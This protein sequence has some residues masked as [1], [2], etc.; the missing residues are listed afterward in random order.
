M[1]TDASNLY[2]SAVLTQRDANGNYKPIAFV[3]GK[4]KGSQLN[5]KI[6][7]KEAYPIIAVLS[8][9]DF[10]CGN[11]KSKLIFKV[12]HANLP[13]IM[14]TKQFTKGATLSRVQRWVMVIQTSGATL[15]T[16]SGSDNVLADG[17]SRWM[18]PDIARA[19][20]VQAMP[21]QE[22]QVLRSIAAMLGLAKVSKMKK[23]ELI[24]DKKIP[25]RYLSGAKGWTEQETQQLELMLQKF[26]IG[27][28][29][30]LIQ[31]NLLPGKTISQMV[32]KT[33]KVLKIQ[34]IGQFNGLHIHP[35]YIREYV[36]TLSGERDK[37]GV[38]INRANNTEEISLV[39]KQK[40]QKK[41]FQ[42]L[43]NPN[44]RI[45]PL[46]PE[47]ISGD[48]YKR[49]SIKE[50]AAYVTTWEEYKKFIQSMLRR[51]EIL[52][53]DFGEKEEITQNLLQM[54]SQLDFSLE[55]VRS[56]DAAV[57]L[58]RR[59][60]RADRVVA[61]KISAKSREEIEKEKEEWSKYFESR[62]S[63]LNPNAKTEWTAI[64]K[65]ELIE[66]QQKFKHLQK[67]VMQTDREGLLRVDNKIWIPPPMLARIVVNTHMM[68][69]HAAVDEQMTDLKK[70]NIAK[71]DR[72][73]IRKA[74]L[75]MKELCLH[76][77]KKA[78]I[79]RRKL[80]SL[81]HADQVN[82]LLRMDYVSINGE[83]LLVITDDLSRRVELIYAES[84]TADVVVD[85]LIFWKARFGFQ[86]KVHLQS[87]N[88][89]HF[90]AKIVKELTNAL[91]MK[92]SF[93]IEYAPWTNGST[94]VS[95]KRIIDLLRSL[96]SE[97][98]LPLNEWPSMIPI[99]QCFINNRKNP[100]TGYSPMEIYYGR[101]KDS[102][103][104]IEHDDCECS[105]NSY[106]IQVQRQLHYPRDVEKLD[107]YLE[108]LADEIA[109]INVKVYNVKEQLR[110]AARKSV[111]DRIQSSD[112]QYQTGE[113][114][115][116][117]KVGKERYPDKTRLIWRGPYMIT[118]MD[119]ENVYKVM[120]PLGKESRLHARGLR[121]YDGKSYVLTEDVRNVYRHDNGS[122]EVEKFVGLKLER[123]EY[124]LK[125]RWEGM[126][127]GDDTWQ[128]AVELYEDVPTLVY[129]YLQSI[130]EQDVNARTLL[131]N[132]SD[133]KGV[134]KK[135]KKQE[136]RAL[137]KKK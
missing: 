117:S 114:V 122:Q 72:D 69:G 18:Y 135:T 61:N 136:K 112:I 11:P 20:H 39:E 29:Q 88:G 76:C 35:K 51:N 7:D 100:K 74:L 38:L 13:Y 84:C 9:Y 97:Y 87:D 108:V 62:I 26:G 89:S 86:K 109:K 65:D 21:R 22:M 54:W 126:E 80:N 81:K 68:M 32:S 56:F 10:I 105:A 52:V 115:M 96:M 71:V 119:G 83:Y 104:A 57:Q 128:R 113:F 46:E 12:D 121:F 2:Y 110:V 90:T 60:V 45:K 44:I 28:W 14:N 49:C 101:G 107:K 6:Q 103:C 5:W 8:R 82:K 19:L 70:Y 40:Q 75:R 41:R 94:E 137:K 43:S 64:T 132:L 120:D 78:N 77:N 33:L 134:A 48:W 27:K 25:K 67:V 116:V 130:A 102:E 16:I 111:N 59:G 98:E 58:K 92:H 55:K 131:V 42:H 17:M 3:S 66:V 79:S 63:P 118:Q 30:L 34:Q 123:G 4:F 99:I 129:G 23:Q 53:R 31:S 24:E 15:E 1:F 91:R 50:R 36:N 95:N 124:L 106:P 73:S 47:H 125:V 85:A 93:S 37:H 133:D 127:E